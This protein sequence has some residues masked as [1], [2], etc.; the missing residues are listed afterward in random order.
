[1]AIDIKDEF[2]EKAAEQLQEEMEQNEIQPDAD[3]VETQDGE[4]PPVKRR[5]QK[6]M[7]RLQR[8]Q[9]RADL[10]QIRNRMP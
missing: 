6:R 8:N 1:M 9:R 4:D 5:N 10:R 2:D 3:T 7:I